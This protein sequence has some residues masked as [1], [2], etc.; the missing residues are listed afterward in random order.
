MD[1]KLEPA[2]PDELA[3]HE[4]FEKWA[5]VEKGFRLSQGSR[6]SKADYQD[7]RTRLAWTA[8]LAHVRR[9]AKKPTE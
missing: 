9:T 2:T 6:A 5:L 3:A 4:A 8:V 1:R 7:D